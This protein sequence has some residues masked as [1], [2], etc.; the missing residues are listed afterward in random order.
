MTWTYSGNPALSQRDALRF[1]VGDTD[2][3]NQQLQ[4]EEIDYLLTQYETV[5]MAAIQA[6]YYLASLYA[7]KIDQSVGKVKYSY[8]KLQDKYIKLAETIKDKQNEFPSAPYC[9]G[10]SKSDKEANVEDTDRVKPAFSK[11]LH[12]SPYT[13]SKKDRY[14]IYENY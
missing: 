13:D 14:S 10:I 5:N 2:D 9:G 3:S 1:M 6:C 8:G 4:N 12:G 7:R 11:D